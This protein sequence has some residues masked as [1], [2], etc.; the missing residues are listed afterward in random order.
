M[1]NGSGFGAS[2]RYFARLTAGSN[3]LD[4]APVYASA[5]SQLL[6]L[7][8][9]WSFGVLAPAA[10]TVHRE[11]SG[12]EVCRA[13]VLGAC[14]PNSVYVNF[15]NEWY[16]LSQAGGW[17]KG[18][19]TLHLTGVG[20]ETGAPG[21][22][23]HFQEYLTTGG[24]TPYAP[25]AVPGVAVSAV[26]VTCV[27]PLWASPAAAATVRLELEGVEVPYD[28]AG[29]GQRFSFLEGWDTIDSGPVSGPASGGTVLSV[30]GYG[31]D[32]AYPLYN[33]SLSR[34][35]DSLVVPGNASA[36]DLLLCA[37]P[38]WGA[39]LF[40][41]P[42][43]VAVAVSRGSPPVALPYTAGARTSVAC[44]LEAGCAYTFQPVWTHFS[45]ASP[46]FGSGTGGTALVVEGSGFN[47]ATRYRCRFDGAG[48]SETSTLSQASSVNTLACTTP[49]W[50][51]PEADTVLT[52]VDEGGG[53][54]AHVG[55][56]DTA[57]AFL[58]EW[59]ETDLHVFAAK[60][61]A[62][63]TVTASGLDSNTGY[64]C[65]FSESGFEA[66]AYA[67]VLDDKHLVCLTPVWEGRAGN[68]DLSIV[69]T[70]GG[71]RRTV[72][73]VTTAGAHHAVFLFTAGWDSREVTSPSV[74]PASGADSLVFRGYGF[75]VASALYSCTFSRGAETVS[76]PAV[77]SSNRIVSC[78][79]P[80]WGVL[81]GDSWGT[82]PRV[83]PSQADS[84]ASSPVSIALLVSSTELP[85]TNG[86]LIPES[87]APCPPA[88]HRSCAFAFY[89][90]WSHATLAGLPDGYAAASLP[91]QVLSISAFGLVTTH[92]YF[93][94]F[95]GGVRP[96]TLNH[97]P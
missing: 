71:A 53:E 1:L 77:A 21:Y 5:A 66:V 45:A 27:T 31:F 38:E 78:V 84:L 37:T 29:A 39:A 89:T 35:G 63:M 62:Y 4:S 10:I 75:D 23:C 11:G 44:S 70:S 48:W 32:P 59:Y 8:P 7:T 91:G 68:A 76:S 64:E 19:E 60:A 16:S 15:F 56:G 83:I 33:C 96:C 2:S 79:T 24:Q 47:P 88:S 25:A 3:I 92:A 58:S 97:Q 40:A 46:H 57:F 30:S 65:V 17:A 55:S 52:L 18:G 80:A 93:C 69:R 72:P 20:F 28:G 12:E 34:A 94:A 50:N 22:T 90:V 42:G 6:I 14:A 82:S 41:Q 95:Y 51:A 54:V 87:T 85:F 74:G 73:F 9:P 81:Y 49:Q 61:R 86:T 43:A 26:D 67:D 36:F 13:G